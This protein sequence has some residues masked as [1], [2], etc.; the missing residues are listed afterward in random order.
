MII[1]ILT[2]T[3][4]GYTIALFIIGIYKPEL[5]LGKTGELITKGW[6]LLLLLLTLM[7]LVWIAVSLKMLLA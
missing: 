3:F 2:L 1:T 5:A 4:I 7:L 6:I